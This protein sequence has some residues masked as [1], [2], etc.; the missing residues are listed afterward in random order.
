MNERQIIGTNRGRESL[1]KPRDS[2]RVEN[3]RWWGVQLVGRGEG[4]SC[5]LEN[6]VRDGERRALRGLSKIQ[7]VS[8]VSRYSMSIR[9]TAN[10]LQRCLL[11]AASHNQRIWWWGRANWMDVR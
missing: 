1:L 8:K 10:S 9:L 3:N 7:S 2:S 4:M 5:E 6:T 11:T